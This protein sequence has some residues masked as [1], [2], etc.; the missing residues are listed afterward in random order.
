MQSQCQLSECGLF[1]AVFY[2]RIQ[3]S[4]DSIEQGCADHLADVATLQEMVRKYVRI[5]HEL[6]QRI[7][8]ELK[9]WAEKREKEEQMTRQ[10]Q[11][12]Q[13][14]AI[15]FTNSLKTSL[16]KLNEMQNRLSLSQAG[17]YTNFIFFRL[18]YRVFT[19]HEPN[20]NPN[21]LFGFSAFLN[22]IIA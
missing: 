20:S 8:V 7:D 3:L 13:N 12:H 2:S 4:V 1:D 19:V 5:E 14:A 17:K 10:K 15:E 21:T 9:Q 16:T 11:Q 22:K 18:A 6:K